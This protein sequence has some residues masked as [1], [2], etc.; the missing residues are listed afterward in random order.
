ML[1]SLAQE[2]IR[3]HLSS[4]PSRSPRSGSIRTARTGCDGAMLYRG[5]KSGRDFELPMSSAIFARLVLSVKRPHTSHLPVGLPSYSPG[6]LTSAP[7][8]AA[9]AAWPSADAFGST[10]LRHLV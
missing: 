4:V 6:T 1:G 10:Y 5:S 3:P 2:G 8:F 7:S 9:S